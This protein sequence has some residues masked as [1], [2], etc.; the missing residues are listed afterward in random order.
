MTLCKS[1]TLFTSSSE[2]KREFLVGDIV[3]LTQ[4]I[5]NVDNIG[6]FFDEFLAIRRVANLPRF[7]EHF[8]DEFTLVLVVV[9]ERSNLVSNATFD[10]TR[11]DIIANKL[12]EF[13]FLHTRKLSH[14]AILEPSMLILAVLIGLLGF[15]LFV[16]AGLR[17]KDNPGLDPKHVVAMLIGLVLMLGGFW[18]LYSALNAM[19]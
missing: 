15:G 19:A 1:T 7:F 18:G 8:F 14:D 16:W 17:M 5:D 4:R 2:R 10:E 13:K 9:L 11:N 3:Q 6:D 12:V